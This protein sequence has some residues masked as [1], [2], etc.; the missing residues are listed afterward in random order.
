MTASRLLTAGSKDPND[1]RAVIARHLGM[2]LPKD[3]GRSDWGGM[4]LTPDQI[5]YSANDVRHLHALRAKLDTSIASADLD[6]VFALE[7][8][9]L[10]A[11]VE[12]E[13]AGFPVH[14]E[15]LTSIGADAVR[16][17]VGAKDQL[18]HALGEPGLNP[19]SPVQLK[20][21]LHKIGMY[22]EDT[23]AETLSEIDHDVVRSVLAFREQEKTSQQAQSLLKA[24]S[25]DGRIHARFEP[26]GTITGRFSSK[27]PNLQNVKRGV[28]RTAFRAPAG[29]SLVVA[30]YSQVELR[31]VAAITGD[32]V[33]LE[34]FRNGEDLH[35]KTAALVLGKAEADISEFDR[36]TAKAVN[37]GLLYGQSATGLV[38]Y[39]RKAYGVEISL[40]DATR[41]RERFFA[42]YRGI[43]AWHKQA[44]RK[45]S[46]SAG[47]ADCCA[48][49]ATGR[50]R[51]M[52]LGGEDWPRF[53][54]LVNTPVQGTC[55]DGLKGAMVRIDALLPA[56]A[57]M[58]A[59]IHD[60]LVILAPT[61]VAEAVKDMVVAQMTAAMSEL[62]PRVPIAVD[63]KVCS[64]WGEK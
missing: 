23:S 9:L 63:A 43:A 40:E 24:L 46:E 15:A 19:S 35:R 13:A 41:M 12:M 5:A 21:A 4:L 61:E 47:A 2:R 36:Q 3:Q 44:W 62:F 1:L 54:T 31:A 20:T 27:E 26:V 8:S 37:F 48:Y 51:L 16:S 29:K 50:R 58:V 11:V 55:G 28:M 32:K 14:R 33:M 30:D 17:M 22:V 45:A 7:M 57:K 64:T 60:E 42:S 52:P 10:P 6:D 34:A 53:A 38:G 39:A 56:S 18:R 59:T 49:T 25:P